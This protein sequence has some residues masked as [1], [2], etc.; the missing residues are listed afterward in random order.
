MLDLLEPYYRPIFNPRFIPIE[1][2]SPV[3]DVAL[4][5][6][7]HDRVRLRRGPRLLLRRGR[8]RRRHERLGRRER[9]AV[10]ARVALRRVPPQEPLLQGRAR[11]QGRRAGAVVQQN[12]M[13]KLKYVLM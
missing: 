1:Y 3:C 13:I 7:D 8:L 4:P 9:G 2:L 12:F 5:L 6:A 10:G 11:L